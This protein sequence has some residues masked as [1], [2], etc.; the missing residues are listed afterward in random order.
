MRWYGMVSHTE[1]P[2]A[3]GTLT[4]KRP[5]PARA[6][7]VGL[8]LAGAAMA[9]PTVS[10]LWAP[11]DSATEVSDHY[12]LGKAPSA[13]L[14]AYLVA[15]YRVPEPRA[16]QIIKLAQ[17]HA[18]TPAI[19][20]LLLLALIGVESNHNPRAVSSVGAQGLMQIMPG[21]HRARIESQWPGATFFDPEAN[22]AVGVSILSE[23]TRSSNGDVRVAL[24]RYNGAVHDRDARYAQRVFTERQRLQQVIASAS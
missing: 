11:R 12:R 1:S 10:G 18:Q 21:L 15:Q 22:I 20:P 24:Q 2:A 6:I 9:M 3:A 4:G 16:E 19:D 23:L 8:A 14:A 13:A 17:I 7:I 5:S